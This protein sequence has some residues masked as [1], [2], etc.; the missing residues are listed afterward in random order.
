MKNKLLIFV[1]PML[2]LAFVSCKDEV[3]EPE[4]SIVVPEIKLEV[5][6]ITDGGAD[7]SLRKVVGLI[8]T[9]KIVQGYPVGDLTDGPD[10]ED[11]LKA[12]IGENGLTVTVPYSGK[13][14]GLHPDT[15]YVSIAV[16]YGSTGNPIC[17]DY[18][19]FRTK[20]LAGAISNENSAGELEE[21]VW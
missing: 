17:I 16:G 18:V 20:E 15:E 5:T 6:N 9:Y 7:I 4:P 21:S 3:E 12:L 2:M 10:N 14:T 1:L 19:V 8:S 13:A 11:E